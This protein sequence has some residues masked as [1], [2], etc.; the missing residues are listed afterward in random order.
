V[1]M[2]IYH[3]KTSTT[4]KNTEAVLD[5]SKEVHLEVNTGKTKYML[6]LFTRVQDRTII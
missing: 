6:G 1:L 3:L 2:L 5:P 4:K